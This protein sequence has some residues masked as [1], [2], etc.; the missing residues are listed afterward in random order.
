MVDVTLAS[1]ALDIDVKSADPAIQKTDKLTA[2]AERLEAQ[3]R[4]TEGAVKDSAAA[5]TYSSTAAGQ[6]EKSLRQLAEV[7]AVSAHETD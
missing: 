6:A 4:K 1:L 2:S 5:Q 3:V 7:S